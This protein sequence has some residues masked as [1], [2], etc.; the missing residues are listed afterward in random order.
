MRC[1]LWLVWLNFIAGIDGIFSPAILGAYGNNIDPN[2]QPKF[3]F[4]II[5]ILTMLL[6]VVIV[7][8]LKSARQ[9]EIENKEF[10]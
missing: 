2:I 5:S 8:L 1:F 4:E 6:L 3:I 9:L 7:H 10:V